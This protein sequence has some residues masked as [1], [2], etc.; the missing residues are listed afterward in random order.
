[1]NLGA[2][3]EERRET[4]GPVRVGVIGAGKFG[5]M[6]L[7]QAVNIPGIHVIAVADIDVPKAREALIRVGWTH[8]RAGAETID[9]A[10]RTGSTC[11]LDSAISMIE[12]PAVELVVEVTGN[13]LAGV[14]HALAAIDNGRHIVMVNV[15][16]DCLVGPLLSE[17]AR[18]AGVI[19]T[20]AY[21][22]QPALICELV[23]WCRSA[24]FDV[25]AAGKGTKYL[26]AYHF[27]TPD[28]VWDH[29]GFTQEQID[30]GDFNPRMFNSFLDGSKSAMEMAAVANATGLV[31]QASGL[32]FPPVGVGDLPEVLRPRS[33]GG[34]L[35]HA[36][37]VEVVSS[38]HREGQEVERDL[39][40]GV[41]VTFSARTEYA[42]QC[43]GEYGIPTD[44]SGE[45]AA[46]YRPFR[47]IGLELSVSVGSAA[48]LGQAT[49]SPQGFWADVVAVTKHDLRVGER[50]DGEG[51]S[52]VFGRLAS[53]TESVDLD[54]LPLGL[55]QGAV[56]RTDKRR[57]ESLTWSDVE[58]PDSTAVRLRR[59]MLSAAPGPS[60]GISSGEA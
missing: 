6:F 53:A 58:V 1:M 45:Y 8:D 20:M 48:V 42:A 39:R 11:V 14:E 9:E 2:A 52:T 37:T 56:L 51:E 44:R 30:S 28:T 17:R 5:S 3:L 35:D 21:G 60:S 15:E 59:E 4:A 22:D 54:A 23:D 55:A 49:G 33:V 46:L 43:F 40:W 19:Y 26:P 57:G 36:P 16:A 10:V 29:Y 24:G 7:T 25:V 18:A 47:L 38:L 32:Q 50:L 12:H 27:S 31:P 13:P 41:Y 34:V